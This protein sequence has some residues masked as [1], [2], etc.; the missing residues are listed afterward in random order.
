MF[1]ATA[2]VCENVPLTCHTN[3]TLIFGIA[4]RKDAENR[5]FRSIYVQ[6][7]ILS[8]NEIIVVVIYNNIMYKIIFNENLQSG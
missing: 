5:F 1:A 6:L 7:L 2:T 3:R 4:N 8:V